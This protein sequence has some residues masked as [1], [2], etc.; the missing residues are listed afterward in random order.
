M[1]ALIDLFWSKYADLR[2]AVERNDDDATA[3][4]DRELDPLLLAVFSS[5]S[6]DPAS[7]QA[8]F[9]FALD[10]LNEE[11]DDRGCVRR[12]GHL[13]QMLV[14]RYV[15]PE[16][17]VSANR[18]PEPEPQEHAV[19]ADATAD[20]FLDD[21]LLNRI[22]DRI[23]VIAPGYRIFYSN[24]TNARRLDLARDALIGRHFAEFVG[25]HRFRN[26]FKPSLDRCFA[27][28]SIS[29]TYADQ[30]DGQTVVIRCRMSPCVSGSSQLIGALLV[31]QETAD[32]RRRPAA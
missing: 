1:E 27:G 14:E 7:I 21:A 22:S 15:V 24:E 2:R 5:Q 23:V 13:L 28:E 8:Q 3:S 4:L 18:R 16:T 31:M 32:R 30:I 26:D 10:L 11:A 29:L 17:G 9:R 20:G 6:K 25:L 19:I 12:N